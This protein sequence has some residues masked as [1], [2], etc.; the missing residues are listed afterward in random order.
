MCFEFK[1][2]QKKYVLIHLMLACIVSLE[3]IM[4]YIINSI[5]NSDHLQICVAAKHVCD[6]GI[7]FQMK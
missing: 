7:S 5:M 3:K 1:K 2:L 6:I 4:Y